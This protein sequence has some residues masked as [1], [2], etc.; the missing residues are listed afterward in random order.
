MNTEITR[1]QNAIQSKN[2]QEAEALAWKLFRQIQKFCRIK[3][4]WID[5]AFTGE[6]C[7]FYRYL[8]EVF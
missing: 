4:T 2:F 6:I 5:I 3:N 1:I 8:Y 7:R